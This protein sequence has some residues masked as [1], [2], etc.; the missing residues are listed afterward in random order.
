MEN[1]KATLSVLFVVLLI[2]SCNTTKVTN[3]S[4][5]E[6]QIIVTST[7]CGSYEVQS[8]E[9]TIGYIV[10]P[11]VVDIDRAKEIT[12]FERNLKMKYANKFNKDYRTYAFTKD[13]AGDT[14]LMTLFLSAKQFANI[15]N[16]KCELQ[17]VDTYPKSS[18]WVY[19]NCSKNRFKVPTE[20][21]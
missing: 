19:Y 9:T 21:D 6:N 20:P 1:T 13:R 10:K 18:E 4:V 3:Q 16:W 2:L 12:E 5:E 8:N 14:I 15:P 17:E 7:Q 11:F